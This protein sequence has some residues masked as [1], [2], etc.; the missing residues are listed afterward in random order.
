M[1]SLRKIFVVAIIPLLFAGCSEYDK[2]LKSENTELKY[3][4]AFEYY[5]AEEYNK[6]S[7]LFKYLVPIYRATEKAAKIEY[8]YAQSLYK[9]RD[10]ILA[11]YHFGKFAENYGNSQYVEDA[12]FKNAYCYYML[13]PRFSLDQTNTYK[14]LDAFQMFMR[15]YPGSKRID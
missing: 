7:T 1:I 14:A 3:K 4:K 10:Y 12:E 15:K 9:Q 13:S 6:A 5:E 11:G 2:I 8:H